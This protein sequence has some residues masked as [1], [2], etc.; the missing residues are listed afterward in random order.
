MARR[1]LPIDRGVPVSD[2]RNSLTAGLH[3]PALLQDIHLIEK[4]EMTL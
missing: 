3:V 4:P 2:N 1:T